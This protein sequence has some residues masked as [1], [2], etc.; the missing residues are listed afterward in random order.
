[1]G[2]FDL[3]YNDK[4]IREIYHEARVYGDNNGM[5]AYHDFSHV[6]NVV[7]L[8]REIMESLDYDD[9]FLDD[10]LVACLLHD[11]GC[12]KGK[13]GHPERSYNFSKDYLK[14]KNIILKN[15]ELVLDAIRNHSNGFDTDNVITLVL[16]LCDKLDIKKNRI[17]S[18]GLLIPGN[19]QYQ[20]IND[21]NVSIVDGC[22]NVL[23]IADEKIDM[24]E[25]NNYYF[26]KKVFKAIDAFCRKM[27]LKYKVSINDSLWSLPLD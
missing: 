18:E 11:T 9:F 12:F 8:C 26:T 15:E 21:I 25:I 1:M 17:T 6:L 22:L 5:W 23:F 19:R 27:N 14:K 7:S 2:N 13:D 16:M 10:V 20:Y 24:D 3:I 4:D